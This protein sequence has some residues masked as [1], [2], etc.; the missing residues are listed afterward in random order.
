MKL[1]VIRHFKVDHPFPKKTFLTKQEVLAW[2]DHYDNAET[3]VYK[4]VDLQNIEWSR[5]Y[6]LEV[7]N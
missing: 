5:C 2:F 1:G 7:M 6:S 3:L 4:N